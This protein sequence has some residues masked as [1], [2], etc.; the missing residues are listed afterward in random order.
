MEISHSLRGSFGIPCFLL[1][2]ALWQ[3]GAITS[4]SGSTSLYV[5]FG[6]KNGAKMES[7]EQNMCTCLES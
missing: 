6:K 2:Q 4:C 5:Y 7:V 3:M 1:S